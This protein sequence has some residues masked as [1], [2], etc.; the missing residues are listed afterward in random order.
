MSDTNDTGLPPSPKKERSPSFP[1]IGLTRALERVRAV[2]ANA[3]RH[4][5]RIGDLASSWGL[6]AKS[7]GT[8]QTLAALLAY[9]LLEDQ[10]SGDARKFKVSDLAFKAL[11]D[12]R[13]GAREAALAE[14]ALK[15]KLIAEYVDKW[16]EGRPA[17]GICISEL[18]IDRS[19]T[20]DGAKLFLK[21][22]DDTAGFTTTAEPDKKPDQAVQQDG[23]K[24]E[25]SG[26]KTPHRFPWE[27]SPPVPPGPPPA[28]PTDRRIVMDS[29]RELTTG[30][31]A[32]EASFRLIVTGKIGVK[33]IDRLIQKLQIDKEI[34]ADQDDMPPG[35]RDEPDRIEWGTS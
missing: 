33:E 31:L 26:D 11:E 32:K 10:G 27:K 19:F 15:P 24:A 5:V 3:R 21:V 17:D 23:Q 28:K 30:M 22:F 20:E 6:G 34:L 29:E 1:F 16:K 2:Y 14:A 13:P 7:S 18:R 8:A 35:D 9:G 4:E 25:E 12:Q